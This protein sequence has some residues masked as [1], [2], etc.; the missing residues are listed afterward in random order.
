MPK[1]I[2]CEIQWNILSLEDWQA[3]FGRI[4][5][6]NL[7]QSYEYALAAC[8]VNR[9][10]ARWGLIKI[11]GVEAGLVQMLEAKALGQLFHALII[12]RGSLWFDGFGAPE[13]VL[14]FT[15][16][17]NRQFP[18]RIGRRRRFI[19]EASGLDILP[20]FKKTETP[21]YQTIWLDLT[22]DEDALRAGLKKKWRN[23]LTKAEKAGL[24]I[25]WDTSGTTL[26]FLI[27]GYIVDKAAKEQEL[28]IKPKKVPNATL[29]GP[30]F[31]MDFCI[32]SLVT[33]TWIIELIR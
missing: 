10:T 31:P 17:I 8:A 12:D 13:H 7:L 24:T 14:A 4:R 2:N 29:L 25:K 27:E 5:R 3:R 22:Q 9:Q 16:E 33:K 26:P 11:D 23:T 19:P 28:E 30:V 15:A 6:A 32:L 21:S 18:K 1:K 20:K